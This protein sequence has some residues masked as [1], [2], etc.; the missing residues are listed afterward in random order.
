VAEWIVCP[1]CALRHRPRAD[2]VCPRCKR[3]TAGQAEEEAA[4]PGFRPGMRTSPTTVAGLPDVFDEKAFQPRRQHVPETRDARPEVEMSTPRR[5]VGAIMVANGIAHFVVWTLESASRGVGAIAGSWTAGFDLVAG[6]VLLSGQG[7]VY[8]WTITRL[9]LGGFV[10]GALHL[11]E[12]RMF[13]LLLSAAFCGGLLTAMWTAARPLVANAALALAGLAVAVGLLQQLPYMGRRNPL[14]H[15]MAALDGRVEWKPSERLEGQGIAYE[16][17][18][19]PGWYLGR[20]NKDEQRQV[21]ELTRAGDDRTPAS[22][23]SAPARRPDTEA[24]L[25]V[26]ALQAPPGASFNDPEAVIDAMVEE[27][28]ARMGDL[29]IL[30]DSWVAGADGDVRVLEGVAR[31]ERQ[32]VGIAL[33]FAVRGRCVL[34]AFGLTPRRSIAALQRDMKGVYT[35][36]RATGCEPVAPTAAPAWAAPPH[37]EP[38]FD[39]PDWRAPSPEPELEEPDYGSDPA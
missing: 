8:G 16:V 15:R 17:P 7:Q 22:E 21:E 25:R 26:F 11:F 12:G 36:L 28:R 27:Q 24:E 10:F 4:T 20:M 29:L 33:G 5:V 18:L 6:A 31:V 9:L 13:A 19:P 37:P 1:G 3:S 38:E 34:M 39:D 2:G 23:L 32:R 14:G 35:G 30:E